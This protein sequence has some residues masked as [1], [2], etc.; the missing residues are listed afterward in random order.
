[1][2][3]YVFSHLGCNLKP[4]DDETRRRNWSHGRGGLAETADVFVWEEKAPLGEPS[5][6]GFIMLVRLSAPF[7][8]I[9]LTTEASR[10]RIG[11]R[12]LFGGNP[13]WQPAFV[14]LRRQS[15]GH[16]FRVADEPRGADE[17]RVPSFSVGV[18]P[19]S[20]QRNSQDMVDAIRNLCRRYIYLGRR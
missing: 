8:S 12:T 10:A 16:A 14:D 11:N 1:M 19:G 2:A 20:E 5:W 4:S 6:F 17:I 7:G 15:R 13:V 9:N 3:E 18:Y